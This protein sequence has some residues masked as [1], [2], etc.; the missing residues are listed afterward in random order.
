LN[1]T[2]L[3]S[4][5]SR[6]ENFSAV[7]IFNILHDLIDSNEL[8]DQ[9][10]INYHRITRVSKYFLESNHSSNYGYNN[11]LNRGIRIFNSNI[12]CYDK[13]RM[14]SVENYKKDRKIRIL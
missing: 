11:P 5:G 8:K 2:E 1:I 13:T 7:F 14:I 10:I 9:V 12:H 3:E 6:R 4:L